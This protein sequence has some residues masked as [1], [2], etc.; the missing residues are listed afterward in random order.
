[1]RRF[2]LIASVL[3]A[4][5]AAAQDEQIVTGTVLTGCIK[6]T[7]HPPGPIERIEGVWYSWIDNSGFVPCAS[8]AECSRFLELG[9]V[10]IKMSD[11]AWD[12]LLTRTSRFGNLY[13]TWRIS[14]EGRRGAMTLPKCVDHTLPDVPAYVRVERVLSLEPL[15]RP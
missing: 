14:F 5:P 4:A 2:A 1:M 13:G 3:L 12:D 15:Q 11:A 8:D 9:S 7:Y 10:D 6:R